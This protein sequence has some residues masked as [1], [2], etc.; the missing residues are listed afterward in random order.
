MRLPVEWARA[1]IMMIQPTERTGTCSS[2]SQSRNA[3]SS[4]VSMR[5]ACTSVTPSQKTTAS[6]SSQRACRNGSLKAW[7]LLVE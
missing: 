7:N 1:N 6:E 4:P 2:V 3:A 5:P